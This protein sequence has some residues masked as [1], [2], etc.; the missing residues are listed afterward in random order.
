[1]PRVRSPPNQRL[2]VLRRKTPLDRQSRS[3]GLSRLGVMSCGVEGHLAGDLRLSG[4]VVTG[5]ETGP[6]IA[7]RLW[8]R[9]LAV[10]ER[11]WQ[12]GSC[13]RDRQVG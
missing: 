3:R 1:M 5:A 2:G 8:A 4:Q 12:A 9:E 6:V 7:L 13:R 10:S 11:D